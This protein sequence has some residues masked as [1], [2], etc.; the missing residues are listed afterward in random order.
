MDFQHTPRRAHSADGRLNTSVGAYAKDWSRTPMSG[1]NEVSSFSQTPLNSPRRQRG[2]DDNDEPRT[3]DCQI[4]PQWR[5]TPVERNLFCHHP[6]NSL[7]LGRATADLSS[8][9]STSSPA[10]PSA[11][12][13]LQHFWTGS[14]FMDTVLEPSEED[15]MHGS[16]S[17]CTSLQSSRA[18]SAVFSDRPLTPV[19]IAGFAGRASHQST[20]CNSS[21][22]PSSFIQNR[23]TSPY[24]DFPVAFPGTATTCCLTEDASRHSHGLD[25]TYFSPTSFNSGGQGSW[26]IYTPMP[27]ARTPPN[28]TPQLMKMRQSICHRKSGRVNIVHWIVSAS[29]LR[30][31]DKQAISE[32]FMLCAGE[33]H[34]EVPF[35]LMLV[36]K[37]SYQKKGGGSFRKAK[38]KGFVQ[39]K[40]QTTPPER[41]CLKF[42]VHVGSGE[43]DKCQQPVRGPYVHDFSSKAVA[44]GEVSASRKEEDVWDFQSC[45]DEKEQKI[46]VSVRYEFVDSSTQ[47]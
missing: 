47:A 10:A 2:Y 33:G 29:V 6:E 20:P 40:A 7:E 17:H 18:T 12:L 28:D 41:M 5:D 44:L 22:T 46:I 14:P 45:V 1:C 9:S 4:Y 35:I 23:P 15:S 25:S 27:R 31:T 3:P 13:C 16:S 37:A 11:G 38:G 42:D 34:L 24:S 32:T 30:S 36:P 19:Q 43:A 39:L 26:H 21:T 8:S